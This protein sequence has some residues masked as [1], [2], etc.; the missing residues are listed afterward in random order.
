MDILEIVKRL[1]ISAFQQMVG[2]SRS[3]AELVQYFSA[4]CLDENG[5][6]SRTLLDGTQVVSEEQD[7][8]GG[9]NLEVM[10]L[11]E[12]LGDFHPGEGN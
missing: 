11:E 9:E 5:E 6:R 1:R 8:F 3:Q 12:L 4:F 10:E 2:L 7:G